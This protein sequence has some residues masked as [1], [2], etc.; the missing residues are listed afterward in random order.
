MDLCTAIMIAL[1]TI[2]YLSVFPTGTRPGRQSSRYNS[3]YLSVTWFP[4]L[5]RIRSQALEAMIQEVLSRPRLLAMMDEFGLFAEER[6]RLKPEEL[7]TLIRR[8]LKIEP[9]ER[10]LGRGD[11]NAFKIS[12]VADNP[13]RAQLITQRLTT[14]FIEQNLKARAD[15]ATTTTEF[16]HEQFRYRGRTLIDRKSACVISKCDILVSF[17]SNSKVIWESW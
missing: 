10:M 6:K 16:L 12:F 11:V 8:D 7:L 3:A 5:L 2:A 15:Q 9:I 13:Q 14:L 4:Q 17:Q 1:G